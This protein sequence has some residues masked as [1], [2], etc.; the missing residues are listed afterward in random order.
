VNHPTIA[1]SPILNAM[2]F[3]G[4]FG[5][6]TAPIDVVAHSRGGL[7]TRWWLDALDGTSSARKRAVLVGSPLQGT[8]LAAPDRLPGALSLLTNYGNALKAAGYL[9]SVY[10]PFL[11]VPLALLR[12]LTS[13]TSFASRTPLI[14]AAVALVPGLSAQS[15]VLNNQESDRLSRAKPCV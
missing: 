13:V 1:V 11:S 2:D 4:Y 6:V 7:V 8:R 5:G 3:A 12:L 15:K 9:A 14:D 10:V